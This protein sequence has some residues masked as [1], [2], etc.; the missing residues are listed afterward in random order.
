MQTAPSLQGSLSSQK[1]AGV[2]MQA[3][4]QSAHSGQLDVAQPSQNVPGSHALQRSPSHAD[5]HRPL[6]NRHTCPGGQSECAL[7]A[8]APLELLLEV[9]PALFDDPPAAPAAPL[10][11]VPSLVAPSSATTVSPPQATSATASVE[12]QA[13]KV[14][15]VPLQLPVSCF[16]FP[17]PLMTLLPVGRIP[18][19]RSRL[20]V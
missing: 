5:V 10:P 9:P 13:N 8:P 14:F 2:R 4:R 3:G 16:L 11:P 1:A 17:V 6:E 7:H 18:V 12:A 19:T 20:S 15:I